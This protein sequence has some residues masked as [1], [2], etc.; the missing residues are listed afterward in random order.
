MGKPTFDS[1]RIFRTAEW[2]YSASGILQQSV[3]TRPGVTIPRTVLNAFSLELYLKCLIAIETGKSPPTGHNLRWLFNRLDSKTQDTIRSSFDNPS[4]K[5]EIAWRE[6]LTNPKPPLPKD[7]APSPYNFDTVL[8]TSAK[9]FAKFRYIFER[10]E[11]A[12]DGAAWHADYIVKCTRRVI[13]KRNP[14]WDKSKT[15]N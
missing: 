1:R 6:T 12:Q 2:F 13:I 11:V 8:D 4:D 15:K 3:P 5:S 7:F 10:G 9:A 14:S